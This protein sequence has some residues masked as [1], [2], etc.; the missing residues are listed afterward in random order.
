MPVVKKEKQRNVEE[1]SCKESCRWKAII[2]T[3]SECLPL[4]LFIQHATSM[5]HVILSSVAF[6]AIPYVLRIIS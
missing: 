5:H 1:R 3:Y 2:I 6:V 4:A